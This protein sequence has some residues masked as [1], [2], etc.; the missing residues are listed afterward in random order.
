M[1]GPGTLRTIRAALEPHGLS[2]RGALLPAAGEVL[3]ASGSKQ[4]A[5]LLLIGHLGSSHW[6]A[7]CRW[8]LDGDRTQ[9]PDPLDRWSKAVIDPIAAAAGATAYYPSDAPY[10]PFQQ[11]A[12]RAEGLHPSPLGILIHPVYGLWHGYRGALAL[13]RM[14]VDFEPSIPVEE[15]PCEDCVGRPCLSTCPAD[16]ILPGGFQYHPCR[17]HL[18]TEAGQDCM[19]QGCLARNACPVGAAYRYCDEQLRFHMAALKR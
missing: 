14:P 1:S 15:F 18:A 8:R 17:S 13:E 10:Q 11:W 19:G 12:M 3:L 6:Q 5:A 4:A 7:F 9:D 2:I 16:A